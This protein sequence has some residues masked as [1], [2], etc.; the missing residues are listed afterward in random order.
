[1]TKIYFNESELK[2]KAIPKVS[3]ASDKIRTAYREM[4]SL[5]IPKTFAYRQKLL[6]FIADLNN[7]ID[8]VEYVEEW[9]NRSCNEYKMLEDNNKILFNMISQENIKSRESIVRKSLSQR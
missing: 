6:E 8:K 5:N 4:N 7:H 2:Y 3:Y 1:M 9:L